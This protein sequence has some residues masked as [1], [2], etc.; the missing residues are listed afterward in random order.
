MLK[1]AVLVFLFGFTHEFS[2]YL[3]GFTVAYVNTHHFGSYCVGWMSLVI[4]I[5]IAA[6]F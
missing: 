5:A 3:T 1:I 6:I 4:D 2:Q